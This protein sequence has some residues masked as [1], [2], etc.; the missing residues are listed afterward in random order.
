MV[1]KH[2]SLIILMSNGG[3]DWND[4]PYDCNAEEPYDRYHKDGKEYKIKHKIIFFELPPYYGYLPCDGYTNCPYSVKDI[5]NKAVAWIHTEDFN[6]L[7][8]TI[9]EEFKRIIRQHDGKIYI[10]EE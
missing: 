10:L 3:D 2:G 5:N 9:L 4:R 7:A 1:T 8:G 6:I